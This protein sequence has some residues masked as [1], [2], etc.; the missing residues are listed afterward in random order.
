MDNWGDCRS[1][2]TYIFISPNY[3]PRRP[4]L[5]KKACAP[6]GFCVHSRAK[7]HFSVRNLH[8][9]RAKSALGVKS[10]VFYRA[11]WGPLAPPQFLAT[12]SRIWPLR[13]L[14]PGNGA[15]RRKRGRSNTALSERRL[16]PSRARGLV[17]F[18]DRPHSRGNGASDDENA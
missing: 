3:F 12:L 6:L 2:N 8:P 18:R 14:R 15:L 13:P 17:V 11:D 4:K 1:F 9:S 16:R 10:V 7:C 5:S